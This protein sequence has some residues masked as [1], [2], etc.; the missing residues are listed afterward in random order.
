MKNLKTI[1]TITLL[2]V[3]FIAFGQSY[4]FKVMANKGTNQVKSGTDWQ[5]LK[6]GTSL[7]STDEL[8]ISENAYLGLIH[9]GG[10]TLEWRDAGTFKV[11]DLAAKVGSGTS[12]TA[13]YADFLASK[14][15]AEGKKNRLSATGA[16]HRALSD[17]A[18][19]VNIPNSGQVYAET[20]I[21]RWDPIE[22]DNIVYKVTVTDMFE[23]PLVSEE[24]TDTFFELNLSDGKMEG[25][26]VVLLM[27]T[28]A[29]DEDVKSGTYAIK[30]LPGEDKKKVEAGL[31]DLMTDISEQT[32]LN[33]YILA[34]FYEENNLLIDA[35]TSYE[36][37][38]TLAPEIDTYKEAYEDFLIRNGLK[39]GN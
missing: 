31:G 14:M 2:G 3:G 24:T 26:N 21:I 17:A 37:A 25:Q 30:K 36:Q 19:N 27:V 7:K 15:S 5:P 13:K 11:S 10:K 23:E 28:T 33:K 22:G 4:T 8:K 12:V 20:A 38:I 9:S 39:Q 16:V 32:A 29:E 18:I 35:L 1:L 6:T 34:G